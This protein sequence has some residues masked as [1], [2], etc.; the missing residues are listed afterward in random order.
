[1]LF[2]Y[3]NFSGNIFA[4]ILLAS[5]LARCLCVILAMKFARH[6]ARGQLVCLNYKLADLGDLS[7][8]GEW[9]GSKF[10]KGICCRSRFMRI[11]CTFLNVNDYPS[12]TL[13]LTIS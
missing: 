4:L 7:R 5:V 3:S 2:I 11:L 8:A 10:C 12:G 13:L 6:C 9:L 1:M